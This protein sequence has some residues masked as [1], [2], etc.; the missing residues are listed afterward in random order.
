MIAYLAMNFFET[1]GYYISL[2][3]GYLKLLI[4][5]LVEGI[6]FIFAS[7]ATIMGILGFLPPLIGAACAAFVAIA[8]LR[9]LLLK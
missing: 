9:F 8:I 5:N 3:A 7:Q 1:I 6:A 4:V 2:Y